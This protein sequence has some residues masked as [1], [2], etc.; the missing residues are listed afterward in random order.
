M[1]LSAWFA[2]LLAVAA[3]VGAD[4]A[5]KQLAVRDLP[6]AGV[7]EVLA[8]VLRFTYAENHDVAFSLLSFISPDV[9][10]GLII[11]TGLSAVVLLAFIWRRRSPRRL[12]DRAAYV[13][14]LGGAL[15]NLLDRVLRGYVVD[16]IHLPGWP[17]FNLADVFICIGIVL[18]LLSLRG[19]RARRAAA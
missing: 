16:F 17:V 9:R 8:G 5:S 4:H 18:F 15:G 14:M 12:A 7:R 10:L 1:R 6:G 19:R 13:L 11:A 2:P 3:L